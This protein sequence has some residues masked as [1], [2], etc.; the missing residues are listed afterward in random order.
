[1]GSVAR[2]RK[3]AHKKRHTSPY[4]AKQ[5]KQAILYNCLS[6]RVCARRLPGDEVGADFKLEKQ[7]QKRVSFLQDIFKI[8]HK[9]ELVNGFHG[10]FICS[11]FVNLSQ[12]LVNRYS[13]PS[14]NVMQNPRNVRSAQGLVSVSRCKPVGHGIHFGRADV[15]VL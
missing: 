3:L 12:R 7:P 8:A 14:R 1:M 2:A 4:A 13:Q 15:G 10:K 11:H 9:S 6:L 5:T